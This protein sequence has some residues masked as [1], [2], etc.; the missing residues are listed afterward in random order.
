MLILHEAKEDTACIQ[1]DLKQGFQK[2]SFYSEQPIGPT[3]GHTIPLISVR[4]PAFHHGE[5]GLI[6]GRVTPGYSISVLFPEIRTAKLLRHVR[7]ALSKGRKPFR[8]SYSWLWADKKC[9]LHAAGQKCVLL[10]AGQKCV[11]HAAG[12][13]CV[14]HAAGQKCI[15]HA[16]GHKCVLHAAEH[17]CTSRCWTQ[18]YFTLLGTSVYLTLLGT[19]VYFPAG[20]KCVL[21]AAGHKCV[22]HAAGHKCVLHAAGHKCI[23]HAAGHKCVL[24]AAEHKCTS[25]CWAQVYFTL[26]G[27]SVYLTLLGTS[28]YFTLLGTSVYLTLLGTSVYLML[29]G[30]SVYFTQ[31]DRSVYLTLLVR[32]DTCF[33]RAGVFSRQS[34][35]L[36]RERGKRM[37][38]W[39]QESCAENNDGPGWNCSLFVPHAEGNLTCSSPFTGWELV[40]GTTPECKDGGN[41]I[42]PR[43]PSDERHRPTRS[44]RAKIREL[45]R[46]DSDSAHLVAV[47]LNTDSRNNAKCPV[48]HL[49]VHLDV[50]IRKSGSLEACTTCTNRG[51]QQFDG[52]CGVNAWKVGHRWRSAVCWVEANPVEGMK[53]GRGVVVMVPRPT[54]AVGAAV[55]ER[56]DCSPPSKTNRIQSPAGSL[57]FSHVGIVPD[58]AAGRWAFS[59]ISRFPR[60]CIPVM[61]HSHLIPLSSV[62]KTLMLRAAKQNNTDTQ[63][64]SKVGPSSVCTQETNRVRFKQGIKSE[65]NKKTQQRRFIDGKTARQFSALRVE[66]MRELMRMASDPTLLGLTR[67]RGACLGREEARVGWSSAEPLGGV[68]GGGV[69]IRPRQGKRRSRAR[70]NCSSGGGVGIDPPTPPLTPLTETRWSVIRGAQPPDPWRRRGRRRKVALAQFTCQALHWPRAKSIIIIFFF[71]SG[72]RTEYTPR[73]RKFIDE[74]PVIDTPVEAFFEHQIHHIFRLVEPLDKQVQPDSTKRL[75]FGRPVYIGECTERRNVFQACAP[76]QNVLRISSGLGISA[77]DYAGVR[78]ASEKWEVTMNGV[79]ICGSYLRRGPVDEGPAVLPLDVDLSYRSARRMVEPRRDLESNQ[80]PREEGP[81]INQASQHVGPG[82]KKAME[83]GNIFH[84]AMCKRGLPPQLELYTPLVIDDLSS[85]YIAIA[86]DSVGGGQT[87]HRHLPYIT[88]KLMRYPLHHDYS[89]KTLVNIIALKDCFFR[90]SFHLAVETMLKRCA[91]LWIFMIGTVHNKESVTRAFITFVARNLI[92]SRFMYLSHLRMVNVDIKEHAFPGCGKHARHGYCARR[93][94]ERLQHLD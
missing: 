94:V 37:C 38:P 20:H 51:P 13:K 89:V 5:L 91:R 24:H 77:F 1:A 19:S 49:W 40:Y 26:L 2:C 33:V 68:D 39:L 85:K 79:Y 65:S 67:R 35:W 54:T 63:N 8:R 16:A 50:R 53:R 28:V 83:H 90:P 52:L 22:L 88:N 74:P 72:V 59:G 11:L 27:T 84:T 75:I 10:V 12:H 14:L 69:D 25:R 21:H 32:R 92:R 71:K 78:G 34:N 57:R 87:P 80:E 23:L 4:L 3:K 31:L 17:K 70:G 9:V 30:T 62:L 58:D 76:L 61:P 81:V 36:G 48:E 86:S 7:D 29:L 43:K 82:G 6:S 55:A 47:N 42:T 44:P 60:P 15:L 45:P 64:I 56:L 46:R 73:I 66:A 18:V 41:G 93:N